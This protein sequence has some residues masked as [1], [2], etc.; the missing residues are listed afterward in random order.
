MVFTRCLLLVPIL[1]TILEDLSG[2]ERRPSDAAELLAHL[3]EFLCTKAKTGGTRTDTLVSQPK[4][5]LSKWKWASWRLVKTFKRE[6]DEEDEEDEFKRS[7]I[8][9]SIAPTLLKAQD[10]TQSIA[11][12]YFC[13]QKYPILHSLL[14]PTSLG[15][16]T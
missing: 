9:S 7:A 4:E 15:F 12:V 1:T 8:E 16:G 11:R 13:T 10:T 6:S 2:E 14:L 3:P 5:V